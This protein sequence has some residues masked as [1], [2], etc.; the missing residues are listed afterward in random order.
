MNDDFVG[1][2]D[3]ILNDET[4]EN[5]ILPSL[6][7]D[8]QTVDPVYKKNILKMQNDADVHCHKITFNPG[9]IV[10]VAKSFDT[11][12]TTKKCKVNGF[13][14][15]GQWIIIERVGSD[16]FKIQNLN[17]QT[18]FQIVCKNRLLKVNS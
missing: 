12:Q 10:L 13:Y 15:E 14:E 16:N 8:I 4:S 5:C 9:D 7:N 1:T 17:V 11:N 18:I 6:N 2:L 3:C